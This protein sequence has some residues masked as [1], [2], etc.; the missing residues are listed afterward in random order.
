MII[1]N[2]RNRLTLKVSIAEALELVAELAKATE[3]THRYG[4]CNTNGMAASEKVDKK[5]VATGYKPSSLVVS[6]VDGVRFQ[7]ED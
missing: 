3:H 2:E 7:N 6:I 5:D 4:H 1:A